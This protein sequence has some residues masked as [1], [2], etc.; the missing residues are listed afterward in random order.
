M[1]AR[2]RRTWRS[3]ARK[4]SRSSWIL[5][6][7]TGIL[8]AT[9][10]LGDQDILIAPIDYSVSASEQESTI[11]KRILLD[12]WWS[13]VNPLTAVAASFMVEFALVATSPDVMAAAVVAGINPLGF[14]TLDARVIRTT[15]KFFTEQGQLS[16]VGV[17]PNTR[18]PIRWSV[19]LKCNFKLK[20]PQGLYLYTRR[21]D[22]D[23]GPSDAYEFSYRSR[24]YVQRP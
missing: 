1:A 15:T 24:C 9:S 18:V 14:Y 5:D 6:E 17:I 12:Y 19:N 3:S 13:P 8:A 4:R 7:A 21:F 20:E 23:N 11:V 2:R 22:T 16:A 10:A